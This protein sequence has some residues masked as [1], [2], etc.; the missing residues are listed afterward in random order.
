MLVDM[1]VT[2]ILCRGRV[3]RAAKKG[4]ETANMADVV[5]LRVRTQTPHHHVMLHALPQ[6]VDRS[7][8]R[9]GI[10]DKFLSLKGTPCSEREAAPPKSN[11]YRPTSPQTTLPRSGFVH[12]GDSRRYCRWVLNGSEVTLAADGYRHLIL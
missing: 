6:R 1:E 8:C 9:D 4:R 10:H 2:Q 3:G 11:I 12:A 7:G 5:L